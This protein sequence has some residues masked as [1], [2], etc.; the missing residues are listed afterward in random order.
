MLGRR[1]SLAVHLPASD[2]ESTLGGQV[3][4][5]F[6]TG[7]VVGHLP[8]LLTARFEPR[9][10]GRG[11]VKVVKG[12]DVGQELR[13]VG[14]GAGDEVDRVVMVRERV[15]R[16]DVSQPPVGGRER[17]ALLGRQGCGIHG[18]Q[19]VER[20]LRQGCRLGSVLVREV[21]QLAVIEPQC[22]AQAEVGDILRMAREHRLADV[23]DQGPEREGL[24]VR[25]SDHG[26][27]Q[28]QSQDDGDD[29]IGHR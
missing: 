8:Q 22:L 3:V 14:M 16:D 29:P 25:G 11:I 19:S 28:G 21:V 9:H 13:E 7:K 24:I 15:H 26:H 5:S 20:S 17:H 12:M 27:G 10:E 2:V 1:Q 23:L 4:R 6:A 18:G